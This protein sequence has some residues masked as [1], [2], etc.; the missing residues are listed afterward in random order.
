MV[1]C[2]TRS[3]TNGLMWAHYAQGHRGAVIELDVE[4]AGFMKE[5]ENLVPAQFGSVVYS[6][7][8]PNH[9]YASS[10]AEGIEVGGTHRFVIGQY[11]KWQ[12][13]F[14]T[15]PL[16]WSYEEEVRI[17]KCLDGVEDQQ[18]EAVNESGD[19]QI[20]CHNTRPLH[21]CKF[22][23]GS[24]KRVIAGARVTPPEA[25]ELTSACDGIPLFRASPNQESFGIGLQPYPEDWL[26]LPVD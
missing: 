25:K 24:I 9:A 26:N 13:L 4:K 21:L 19:W 23:L 8:R 1:L 16:V 15:K 6:S 17:V 11:E 5:E 7:R 10:V 2:L 22:P 3:P 14:L 12:R 18:R 20:I